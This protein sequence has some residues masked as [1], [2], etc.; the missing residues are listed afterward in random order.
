MACELDQAYRAQISSY[1]MNAS[2][3]ILT[4]MNLEKEHA[5]AWFTA[6]K[7]ETILFSQRAL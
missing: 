4:Q 6:L 2:V 5:R 1:Q 7:N 3:Y